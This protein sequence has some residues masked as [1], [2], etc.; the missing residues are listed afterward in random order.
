MNILLNVSNSNMQHSVPTTFSTYNSI[1]NFPNLLE[2]TINNVTYLFLYGMFSF[3][4]SVN[5]LISATL[6]E[7][8]YCQY[9]YSSTKPN[10]AKGKYYIEKK[11]HVPGIQIHQKRYENVDECYNY[12]E[13]R[14]ENCI[15]FNHQ[16]NAPWCYFVSSR[17][18]TDS[19]NQYN[20]VSKKNK[21]TKNIICFYLIHPLT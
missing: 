8:T 11:V 17:P 4:K 7:I 3:Y 14:G 16:L 20:F 19:H 12:C 18:Q 9:T 13:M 2:G 5:I 15:G 21:V 1:Y 6:F 10:D